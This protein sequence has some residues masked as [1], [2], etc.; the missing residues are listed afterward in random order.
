MPLGEGFEL[1]SFAACL[2]TA[3]VPAAWANLDCRLTCFQKL[4]PVN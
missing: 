2:T 1:G 4:K 3:E